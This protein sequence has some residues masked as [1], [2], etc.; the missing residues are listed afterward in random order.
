[1]AVTS[2]LVDRLVVGVDIERYSGRNIRHQQM[3]QNDLSRLMGEAADDAG[4]HRERWDR[5]WTG[6]GELAVLPPDA[7]LVAVVGRFVTELHAR[8]ATRNEDSAP[9][10]RMRLRMAIHQDV[11]IRNGSTLA[12]HALL[13]LSRLLD[14]PAVRRALGKAE[15][16]QLALIVSQ[17]VYRKVV[18]SGLG[19][20]RPQQ[21]VEARVDIPEKRFSELAYV[22]VPGYDMHTFQPEA[23]AT[24]APSGRVPR[25][26]QPE[27]PP[28]PRSDR[29]SEAA[30]SEPEAPAPVPAEPGSG[31]TVGADHNAGQV[32]TIDGGVHGPNV[33]IGTGTFHLRRGGA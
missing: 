21:F 31:T 23:E 24:A 6:D 18:E 16:A 20:L 19:G 3:L 26:P 12:G 30:R 1:M 5:Q 29:E 14:A 4:I 17:P 15:H 10:L 8:L 2:P 11:V 13:N 9:E 32:I 25:E 28:G 7:D 27:A 33:H 22:H